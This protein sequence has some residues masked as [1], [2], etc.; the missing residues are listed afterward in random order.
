MTNEVHGALDRVYKI[1]A[2]ST[3]VVIALFLAGLVAWKIRPM[4]KLNGPITMDAGEYD[5]V[6]IY[7]VGSTAPA[8]SICAKRGSL[9]CQ[10]PDA[11]SLK[12]SIFIPFGSAL[13]EGP[14]GGFLA[15][16]P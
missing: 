2:I 16:P 11:G 3:I 10:Q 14:D 5:P 13:Y 9:D 7:I 6:A 8:L 15:V 4:P 1:T 12:G